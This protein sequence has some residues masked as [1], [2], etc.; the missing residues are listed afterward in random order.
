MNEGKNTS[1]FN[2][3]KYFLRY[4]GHISHKIAVKCQKKKDSVY[5]KSIWQVLPTGHK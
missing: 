1:F 4:F 2:E 5:W 3:N